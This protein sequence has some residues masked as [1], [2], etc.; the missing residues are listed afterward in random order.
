MKVAKVIKLAKSLERG[1]TIEWEFKKGS[2]T[3][4]TQKAKGDFYFSANHLNIYWAKQLSKLEC[5]Y[6]YT[7]KRVEDMTEADWKYLS[8]TL[9]RKSRNLYGGC[10]FA[11]D[12]NKREEI[13]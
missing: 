8:K 5:D 10:L 11:Y 2:Y 1:Q 4:N 6:D 12:E 7:E 9:G 13:I 3:D